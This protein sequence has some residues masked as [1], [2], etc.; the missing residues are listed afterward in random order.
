VTTRPRPSHRSVK[1]ARLGAVVIGLV[2]ALALI[3][4]SAAPAATRHVSGGQLSAASAAVEKSGV[5]GV[6]WYVD[7]AADRVVVTADGSVSA[8]DVA[9]IKRQ[10]GTA[11]SVIRF[12]R[13][14]GA[15]RS[16]VSAGDA[17]YGT[18]YRC[19]LGFNV[20]S[21]STYYFL[22]AGH[23]GKSEKTWYTGPNRS[24][25][26]GPTIGYSFPDNDYSL[27]RYDNTTL[28]HPGGFTVADAVVGETVTRK[29]STTGVHSGRVTALNVTVRYQGGGTVRGMIQTTVCAEPGDSGGPLYDGSKALG[30]TSGGSG[31]CQT[32]GT[33]FFQPVREAVN[34]YG[35][36]ML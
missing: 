20:V 28:T 34:A 36:S 22:T 6:A 13:A 15:F 24:A 32:G 14:T 2:A 29:G 3:M 23:C 31:N 18:R 30:L 9:T 27:V 8:D 21:G 16:L 11:A 12:E 17:I 5:G 35:V 7:A 26:I 19:S 1:L 33:T 4:P 25:L 10:A